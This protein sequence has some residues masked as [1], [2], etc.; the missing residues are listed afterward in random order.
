M[1]IEERNRLVEECI[2]GVRS[3]AK[4]I[5]L[6]GVRPQVEFDDLAS[7]GCQSAI[8]TIN[9]GTTKRAFILR[10]AK[11]RMI[12]FINSEKMHWVG[13]KD[14]I[15]P[16]HEAIGIKE[17]TPRGQT[18]PGS[19]RIAIRNAIKTLPPK[20]KDAVLYCD[21]LGFSQEEAGR[22][23]GCGHQRISARLM[24]A[25]RKLRELLGTEGQK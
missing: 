25:K 22:I 1:T 9:A 24:R 15:H 12:E 11:S 4:R 19:D 8:Q 14:R 21:I 18:G 6:S 13:R 17:W 16:N 20:Q 2:P 5:L 3:V 7:V 23:L 10:H